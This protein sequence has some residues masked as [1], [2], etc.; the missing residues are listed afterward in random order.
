VEISLKRFHINED[1]Q[2]R[3]TR[4][5]RTVARTS[6]PVKIRTKAKLAERV[7]ARGE[8]I[9]GLKAIADW[10]WLDVKSLT[11]ARDSDSGVS[12][13][14]IKYGRT[15]RVA[16]S[17][18]IDLDLLLHSRRVEGKRRGALKKQRQGRARFA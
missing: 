8:W 6:V 7:L 10:A 1:E 13:L 5:T 3:L 2:F 16:R 14:I 9:E 15:Y 4:D 12:R 11:V 18:L 17:D